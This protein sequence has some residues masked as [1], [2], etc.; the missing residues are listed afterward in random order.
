MRALLMTGAFVCIA[1]AGCASGI[2]AVH[3]KEVIFPSGAI[4]VACST[5]EVVPER[6]ETFAVAKT[7]HGWQ[8]QTSEEVERL[9]GIVTQQLDRL[10]TSWMRYLASFDRAWILRRAAGWIVRAIISR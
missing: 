5:V 8:R 2:A 7:V 10:R 4:P 1:I 6:A 3:D 9:A